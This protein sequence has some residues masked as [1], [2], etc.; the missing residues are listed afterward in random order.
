MRELRAARRFTRGFL[1]LFTRGGVTGVACANCGLDIARHDT[2]YVVAHFH[3]VL[4]IGVVFAVYAGMYYW[5]PKRIGRRYSEG[6]AL[7]H[8]V[9]MFI[10]VNR[11]FFPIHFR[12][13]AGIPRRVPDYADAYVG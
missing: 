13:R 4:S 5:Y 6:L 3:Y 8:F 12:G 9:T 7:V 2:Y 1:V 10:G 11:T